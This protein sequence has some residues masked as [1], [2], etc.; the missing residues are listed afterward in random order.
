MKII[1][2]QGQNTFFK[3]GRFAKQQGVDSSYKIRHI[4]DILNCMMKDEL[5]HGQYPKTPWDVALT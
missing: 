1:D 5:W 4:L 2:F 3:N